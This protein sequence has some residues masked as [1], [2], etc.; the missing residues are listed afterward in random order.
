MA[1]IEITLDSCGGCCNTGGTL[2]YT[3]ASGDNTWENL[4]N[5]MYSDGQ[6]P[7]E[8]PWLQWSSLGSVSDGSTAEDTLVGGAGVNMWQFNWIG[9]ASSEVC[10]ISSITNYASW[11]G[12]DSIWTGDNFT[13][14][15]GWNNETGWPMYGVIFGPTFTGNNCS[16]LNGA[17]VYGGTFTGDNFLND[18]FGSISGSGSSGP[19]YVLFTGDNFT[20]GGGGC[21]Y[22]GTFTGAG[23]QNY[24][25]IEDGIFTGEGFQNYGTIYAGTFEINGFVDY[26]GGGGLEF[27]AASFWGTNGISITQS[28]VPYTGSWQG[29]DWV[30]GNWVGTE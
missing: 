10:N 11:L 30:D 27:W 28:G 12:G 1:D 8:I 20:N 7:T 18:S 17:Y 6:N 23:F 26:T 25:V 13:N 4:S 14:S 19:G 21:I 15:G 16:N 3:N 24:G 2:Y 29:Q 9:P 22:N 5:W